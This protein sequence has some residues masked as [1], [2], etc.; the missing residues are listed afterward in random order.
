[1][2]CTQAK[3]RSKS[4]RS[5]ANL[6]FNDPRLERLSAYLD[7]N[8]TLIHRKLLPFFEDALDK[9]HGSHHELRLA[10]VPLIEERLQDLTEVLPLYLH[11]QSLRLWKAR[12]GHQGMKTL[13]PVLGDLLQLKELGLEDNELGDEG[14]VALAP[15]LARLKELEGLHLHI[16]QISDSGVL[17][18]SGSLEGKAHLH[19]LNLAE[20]RITA[21]GAATLLKRLTTSCSQLETLS[22]S[23]N[24][25]SD[26]SSSVLL[27][28]IHHLPHLRKLFL[29]G[30]KLKPEAVSELQR[31]NPELGIFS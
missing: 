22:L 13:A 1:M 23:A 2:G 16:N 18:L 30:I 17:A 31:L 21:V 14:A 24:S 29:G 25:L 28:H 27:T 10:F 20:N 11:L 4:A 19:I 15:A 7:T 8:K 26:E 9:R 5:A 3:P 6:P 12:L